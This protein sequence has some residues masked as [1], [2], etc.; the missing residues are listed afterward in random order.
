MSIPAKWGP[1]FLVN[2]FAASD[3]TEPVVTALT[4]GRFVVAWTDDSHTL[5]DGSGRAVHAQIFH[6]D[7]SRFGAGF[8]AQYYLLHNPD[9]AAA[10]AD[11]L[12]H[13]NSFGRHEGRNPNGWF[14]TAGYLAH[15][16]D[17]AAAGVNPL[18]HYML[19]GWQ[20]GR[21]PSA[22]FDTLAYLAANPDVAAAGINPLDHFLTFGIYEGRQAVND[23]MWH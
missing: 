13:F 4:N 10:G 8:D 9:V 7:G 6:A 2:T 3:Q 5:G 19:Y 1:E 23:G 12:T 18:E 17:V 22:S 14:D 15:Y 20:E 21:D 16:A 11:P